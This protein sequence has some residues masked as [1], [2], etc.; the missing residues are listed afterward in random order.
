MNFDG[1]L[2]AQKPKFNSN[3]QVKCERCSEIIPGPIRTVAL[4]SIV[5]HYLN[6][7]LFIYE[8]KSGR[9]SCYCSK[10]CRNKHNH[11]FN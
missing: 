6:T 4:G 8:S 1:K 3:R 5:F 2:V 7:K 11:R 9:A 10:W